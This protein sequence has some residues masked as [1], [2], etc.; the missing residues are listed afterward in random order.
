MRAIKS[1]DKGSQIYNTY[2]NL[3]NH[4][5]LRRYGYILP[6]SKDDLVEISTDLLLECLPKYTDDELQRRINILDEEDI[7][8]ESY[9]LLPA[10]LPRTPIIISRYLATD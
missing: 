4:D 10:P 7:F 2:G 9:S 1:I 6:E 8:E 3:P 5:L